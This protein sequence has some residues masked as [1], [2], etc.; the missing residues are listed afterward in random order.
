[1]PPLIRGVVSAGE[2]CYD[3]KEKGKMILFMRAHGKEVLQEH[4]KSSNNSC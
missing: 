3:P 2:S 1:M 4:P